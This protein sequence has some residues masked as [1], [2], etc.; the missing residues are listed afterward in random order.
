[1]Y[2]LSRRPSA[3]GASSHTLNMLQLISLSLS[4]SLSCLIDHVIAALLLFIRC[5]W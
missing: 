4:L 2:D 1:M 3:N 5:S